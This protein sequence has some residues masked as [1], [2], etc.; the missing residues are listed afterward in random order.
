[1][2]IFIVGRH[3]NNLPEQQYTVVGSEAVTFA[4]DVGSCKKQLRD[5]LNKATAQ[6]AALVLQNTPGIVAIALAQLAAD[7]NGYGL[8][9]AVGVIISK[10]APREAGVARKFEIDGTYAADSFCKAVAFANP[11]AKIQNTNPGFS[12]AEY[13]VTVDPPMK[14]E[15]SHIEWL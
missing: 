12:P 11:N 8:G 13:T 6:E 15:F 7:A 9:A 4:T 3:T 5:L 10:V 14:F 1:M 2:N